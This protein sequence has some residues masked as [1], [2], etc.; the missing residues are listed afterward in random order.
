MTDEERQAILNLAHQRG[1][2]VHFAKYKL[3]IRREG[4]HIMKPTYQDVILALHE[5]I[6]HGVD[7]VIIHQ[8]KVWWDRLLKE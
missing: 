6:V 2:G 1:I 5:A 3:D 8:Q 4:I 7:L